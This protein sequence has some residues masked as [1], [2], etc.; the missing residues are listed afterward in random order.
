MTRDSP[1]LVTGA[2]G[3]IA[4]HVIAELL[5]A[6]YDVRGTVRD[7]K[8]ADLDY[9]N[10]KARDS[11]RRFDVARASL[12]FDDGWAQAIEGVAAI[13]HVASPAPKSR[14]RRPEELIEPAVNGTKRV[15][16]AAIRSGVR[17]V[18]VTSSIDAVRGGHDLRDGRVR[19]EEDWSLLDRCDPYSASKTLA[20]QEAWRAVDST[21][22]EL[23]T[24]CPGL[25]LG[26]LQRPGT[27]VSMD[28]IEQL[29]KRTLPA[30]PHIGFSVVDVRDVARAHRLALE[31][32]SAAG[33]RYFVAGDPSWLKDIA[34]I[35]AAEYAPR[36]YQIPLAELPSTLVRL[37][38]LVNS[39]LRLALPLLDQ[40]V[41]VSS[42]RAHTELGWTTRLLRETLIDASET[43]ISRT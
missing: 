6:G 39:S 35:L 26:P 4:G 10:A 8:R 15:L 25:V 28:I 22:L 33:R 24:V 2:T 31:Q 3:F 21:G 40:P 41:L 27:N 14:P 17:R 7:P 1:V 30:L 18:V 23:V 11:G 43:I 13:I 42:L 37:G 9:L 36:G 34:E 5:D 32:T 12:D 29:L 16:T 38:A 20:E 19:T